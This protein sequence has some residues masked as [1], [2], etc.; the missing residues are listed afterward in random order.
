M[1]VAVESYL[2]LRGMKN[3]ADQTRITRLP[4]SNEGPVMLVL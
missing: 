4:G 3:V 2:L 1:N